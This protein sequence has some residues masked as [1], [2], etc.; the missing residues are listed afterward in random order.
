MPDEPRNKRLYELVGRAVSARR[1]GKLTQEQLALAIGLSRTSVTNLEAGRQ[2]TPLHILLR[3]ADALDCELSDLMPTRR[4]LTGPET[5][6]E[7][8]KILGELTPSTKEVV[9][10]YHNTARSKR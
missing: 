10:R 7:P 2:R 8:L 5:S 3:V 1:S 4:D 6:G 9:D